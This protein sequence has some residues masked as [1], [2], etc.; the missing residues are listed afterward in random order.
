MSKTV[1][2][3]MTR[4]VVTLNEEDNLEHV[5][6]GL[7]R[8]RFHHLPV[9][10]GHKL[11]GM[12]SQR[13]MLRV[14]TSSADHTAV[15]RTREKRFF[16]NTFVR[17]VMRTTLVT[18]RAEEPVKQAARRMLE[19]RYGALPVVDGEGNLV[20]ILTEN[21]IVRLAAQLLQ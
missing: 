16:E 19:M 5:A 8:F 13:D 2:D 4:E 14:A 7:A 3:V 1:G 17:D 9:V 15:S 11:V 10:D 12:L 6:Q 21:D 18:A 20:G